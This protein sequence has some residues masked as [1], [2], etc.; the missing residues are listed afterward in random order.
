MEVILTNIEEYEP[1]AIG[2]ICNH[3]KH[4]PVAFAELVKELYYTN[5]KLHILDYRTII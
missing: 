3:E 4:R 5:S 1:L 2:F